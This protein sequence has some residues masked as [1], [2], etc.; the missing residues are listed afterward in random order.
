LVFRI[1]ARFLFSVFV[2]N[3]PK[4]PGKA[5]AI[6]TV[7]C[8]QQ[9]DNLKQTLKKSDTKWLNLYQNRITSDY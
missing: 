7:D 2:P 3:N 1:T 6:Q 9:A 4:V 8:R 5:S